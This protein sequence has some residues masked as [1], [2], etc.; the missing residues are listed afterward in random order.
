MVIWMKRISISWDAQ[1]NAM[2][3]PQQTAL[4]ELIASFVLDTDRKYQKIKNTENDLTRKNLF[5]L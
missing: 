4:A 1:G 2:D 3:K 5:F